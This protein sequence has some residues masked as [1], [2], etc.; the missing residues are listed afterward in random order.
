V[1]RNGAVYVVSCAAGIDV[2]APVDFVG[3][4]WSIVALRMRVFARLSSQAP[5][6]PT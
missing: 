6:A 1:L 4:V 2:E 5:F 3:M